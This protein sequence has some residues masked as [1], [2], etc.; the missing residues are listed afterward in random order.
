MIES[1]EVR[2]PYCGEM[3][4]T[5]ADC[6]AGSVEYQEDCQICCNPILFRLHVDFAGNLTAVDVQREDGRD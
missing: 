6:S 4:E 2:C 3:F 5:V 1:I